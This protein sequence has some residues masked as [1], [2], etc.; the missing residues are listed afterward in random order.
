MNPVAKSLI[1]FFPTVI[2]FS[3]CTSYSSN[4]SRE[5]FIHWAESFKNTSSE[6]LFNNWGKPHEVLKQGGGEVRYC[7]C[8]RVSCAGDEKRTDSLLAAPLSGT[9]I[10]TIIRNHVKDVEFIREDQS[11]LMRRQ[12]QYINFE[13]DSHGAV[14]KRNEVSRTL[15]YDTINEML[16][17]LII[18]YRY[19]EYCKYWNSDRKE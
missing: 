12:W 2:L 8:V 19:D 10:F 5:E 4:C 13:V 3:S 15:C 6:N 1:A 16:P 18:S 7:Y 11:G 17:H 14:R 9:V